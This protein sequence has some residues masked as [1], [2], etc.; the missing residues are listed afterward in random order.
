MV[1]LCGCVVMTGFFVGVTTAL[2]LDV[3]VQL[4]SLTVAVYV[5]ATSGATLRVAVVPLAMVCTTPSDQVTVNGAVPVRVA[6]M[7]LVVPSQNV[8]V[9][10]TE[11]VGVVAGK[12]VALPP[13]DVPQELETAVTL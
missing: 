10:L 7:A 1:L 9:P 5:V 2:P 3:P 12:T 8:P 13:I 4:A 11:T 6:V